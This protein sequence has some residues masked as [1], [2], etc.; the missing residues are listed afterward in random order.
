M[1]CW[2]CFFGGFLQADDLLLCLRMMKVPFF[3][4]TL[5]ATV[6]CINAFHTVSLIQLMRSSRHS[7]CSHLDP[8]FF[9]KPKR[10]LVFAPLGSCCNFNLQ[11]NC[12]GEVHRLQSQPHS[13]EASSQW[14]SREREREW[15]NS[16][17]SDV[18]LGFIFQGFGTEQNVLPGGRQHHCGRWGR[19]LYDIIFL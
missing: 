14:A 5:N 18:L 11:L 7:V 17:K 15:R 6:L 2:T 3:I 13:P 12:D 9:R 8:L 1:Q 10:L 4:C 16:L 19:L